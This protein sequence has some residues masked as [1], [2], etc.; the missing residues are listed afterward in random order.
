[1]VKKF[2]STGAAARFKPIAASI[3]SRR[4]SKNDRSAEAVA[5]RNIRKGMN[6]VIEQYRKW[7]AHMDSVQPEI[8]EQAFER[9]LFD[10]L[11]MVP[12]DTGNL[13]DSAY[14]EVGKAG[15]RTNLE[16]G[17]D[18]GSRLGYAAVVHENLEWQHEPPTRAKYLEIALLQN[19]SHV[20]ETIKRLEK[21]ASGT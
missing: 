4:L 8:L 16:I 14:L 12:R 13:A 21:E 17:Y 11:I 9:V 19:A 3:G 5:I 6:E 18:K 2:T 20:W 10:S 7:I 1:M 15:T